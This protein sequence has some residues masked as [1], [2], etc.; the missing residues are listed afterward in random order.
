VALPK[1]KEIKIEDEMA[2]K[3]ALI[4]SRLDFNEDY[5]IQN[6]TKLKGFIRITRQR[7]LGIRQHAHARQDLH[8]PHYTT[9]FD[10]QQC[11]HLRLLCEKPTSILKIVKAFYNITKL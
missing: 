4:W 5:H 6:I 2:S 10:S 8:W 11:C 1:K 3:R 9:H 7:S